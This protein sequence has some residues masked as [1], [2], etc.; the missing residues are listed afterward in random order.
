[1][2]ARA[3]VTNSSFDG[4]VY[5]ISGVWET[6]N[7]KGTFTIQFDTQGKILKWESTKT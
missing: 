7:E 5:T 1:M 2:S 4:K 6:G 3:G